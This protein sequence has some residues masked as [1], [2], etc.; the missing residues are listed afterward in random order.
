MTAYYPL[1][2]PWTVGC[3]LIVPAIHGYLGVTPTKRTAQSV[4]GEQHNIRPARSDPAHGASFASLVY[5]IMVLSACAAPRLGVEDSIDT[6]SVG[7]LAPAAES[8]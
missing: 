6:M 5:V 1:S 8:V 2:V 3:T 7:A 4:G